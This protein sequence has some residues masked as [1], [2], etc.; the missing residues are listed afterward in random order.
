MAFAGCI[1]PDTEIQVYAT[2][3]CGYQFS[4]STNLAW[5]VTGDGHKKYIFIDDEPITK[6]WC[7]SPE[8]NELMGFPQSWIYQQIL[9]DIVAACDTRAAE[10]ELGDDNC[11]EVASI[12]Y[13][14]P[15]PGK[16]AW[17]EE[18]G[19]DDEVGTPD[20]PTR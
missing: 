18:E 20:L 5:G 11:S 6:K 19:G 9:D 10:M 13:S 14:G 12:A 1:I 15:C 4:A 17:C 3:E 16:H 7:L 2:Q 8:E